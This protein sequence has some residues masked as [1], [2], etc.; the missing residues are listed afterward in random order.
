MP[1]TVTERLVRVLS[2]FGLFLI[3]RLRR[4]YEILL[5]CTSAVNV[6]CGSSSSDDRETASS[7]ECP[8]SIGDVNFFN[9][10]KISINVES[11][12]LTEGGRPIG[13]VL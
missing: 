5:R 2:I 8:L 12:V 4:C 10:H 11:Y 7:I 9:V 1:L 13:S 3:V 6:V